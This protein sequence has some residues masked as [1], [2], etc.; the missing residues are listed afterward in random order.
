M[1]DLDDT[2]L[3]HLARAD[4]RVYEVLVRRHQEAVFRLALYLLGDRG[5]AEKVAQ[6]VFVS[7]WRQ[8]TRIRVDETFAGLLCRSATVRCLALLRHRD[9]G[10]GEV[11]EPVSARS[12][13]RPAVLRQ[14]LGDLP[15]RQRAC[16]LLSEVYGRGDEEIGEATGE[17]PS[18]VRLIVARARARLAVLMNPDG[19]GEYGGMLDDPDERKVHDNRC[20]YPGRER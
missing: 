1:E 18:A 6:D 11:R 13:G 7:A 15:P 2:A 4:P 8:I 20:G 5:E 3:V 16:W 12:G 19:D 9:P 17:S 10:K 14:G